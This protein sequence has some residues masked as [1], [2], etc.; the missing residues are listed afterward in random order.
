MRG[1]HLLSAIPRERLVF[2]PTFPV[3]LIIIS[4]VA[5]LAACTS[6]RE[7]PV[8]R[9]AAIVVSDDLTAYRQVAEALRVRLEH[10]PVYALGGD[11][12][13]ASRLIAKLRADEPLPVIAIGALATRVAAALPDRSI[14]FCQYFDPDMPGFLRQTI[15]GVQATP[16]ALKQLQ[17]WKLLDPRLRRI[18]LVT[19]PSTSEFAREA[20]AAAARLDVELRHTVVHSDRELLYATKRI[21]ADVQGLWLVPDHQVLSVEILR[22]ALAHSLRQGRQSLVFSSQL[23]PYGGLLSVEGDP[24][25]IAERVLE[26]LQAGDPAVS[27]IAPLKRARTRVNIEVARQLGLEV[28]AAMQDGL[29]V[30]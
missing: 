20:L 23:L 1:T 25:D 17:A 3:V 24:N 10:A 28:P 21:D 26:Q 7:T 30:F 4:A 2:A 15:R 11:P 9:A 8:R 12:R 5:L 14:V 18:A 13:N 19:G 6:L 16:P 29:Y 27:R 22:E